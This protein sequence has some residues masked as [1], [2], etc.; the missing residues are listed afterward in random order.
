[1]KLQYDNR[2]TAAQGADGL[3]TE[4][5]DAQMGITEL[6]REFFLKQNGAPPDEQQ[7]KIMEETAKKTGGSAQ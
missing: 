2:R 4:E 3:T 7:E 6:F 1:M 5:L